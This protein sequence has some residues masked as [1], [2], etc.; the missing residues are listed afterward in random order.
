MIYRRVIRNVR[1]WGESTMMHS[2]TNQNTTTLSHRIKKSSSM[3]WGEYSTDRISFP[4]LIHSFE[5][6]EQTIAWELVHPGLSIVKNG[7][8]DYHKFIYRTT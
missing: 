5:E 1:M 3:L 7:F 6:E 2:G 4:S 8:I